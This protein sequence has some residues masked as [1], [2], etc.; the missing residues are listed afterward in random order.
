VDHG[1]EASRIDIASVGEERPICSEQNE[2]CW[3]QNRRD[4]FVIV[5]GGDSL[6]APR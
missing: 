4:E 2:S 6:V 1:V 3:S 5:A